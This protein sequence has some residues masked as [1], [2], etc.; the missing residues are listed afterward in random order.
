METVISAA[1]TGLVT[2]IV[3]IVNNR[4]QNDKTR[5][6]LDYRLSLLEQKQDKHN[7]IIERTFRLEGRMNEAEHEIRDLKGYHKPN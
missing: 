3:C 5:A 6:L 2:L 4:N 7:M 1:I